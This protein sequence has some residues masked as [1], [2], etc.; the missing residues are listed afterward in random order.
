MSGLCSITCFLQPGAYL[1]LILTL[2]L[3]RR[4]G[5]K[6][7]GHSLHWTCVRGI[8]LDEGLGFFDQ[9]Q[10][11]KSQWMFLFLCLLAS[12]P[13]LLCLYEIV[14]LPGVMHWA[15]T[16]KLFLQVSTLLWKRSKSPS[17]NFLQSSG[18]NLEKN[19]MVKIWTYA[20]GNAFPFAWI[21]KR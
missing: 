6:P 19:Y 12:L 20:W 5:K 15:S 13:F 14:F 10:V 2:S 18:N 1:P 17:L 9:K 21:S 11:C 3:C 4:F 7:C 16:H 8:P